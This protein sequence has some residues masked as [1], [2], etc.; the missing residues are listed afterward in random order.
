[1]IIQKERLILIFIF[2]VG[3]GL[4]TAQNCL[5]Q[6]QRVRPVQRAI[7]VDSKDKVVGE[8]IGGAALLYTSEVGGGRQ[9]RASVLLSVDQRHA[10]VSLDRNRF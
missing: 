7:I 2:A 3:L 10:A 5:A 1:M 4:A 8:T 6:Q 9:L